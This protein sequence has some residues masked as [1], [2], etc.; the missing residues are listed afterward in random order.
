M[1]IIIQISMLVLHCHIIGEGGLVVL[2][3][4][5]LIE[6][7]CIQTHHVHFYFNPDGQAIPAGP[8]FPKHMITN[9]M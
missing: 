4:L 2:F 1:G 6:D 8:L 9:K 7:Q 5:I 3:I